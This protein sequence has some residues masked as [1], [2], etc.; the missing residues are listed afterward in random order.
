MT[1]FLSAGHNPKGIR[2]DSGAVN[3]DGIR[4]CDK[5]IEFRNLMYEAL[6]SLSQQ[7]IIPK[8][9]IM[10]QD[11]ERLGDYL[12]RIKTGD[13]SVVIE[14]HFDAF[15]GIAS[16]CTVLIGNDADRLDKAFA[17]EIVNK[18]SHIL[19]I[20][21]R[22]VKTETDSHRGKLGLMR[23]QGTV[24]LLE[25]GFIDNPKDMIQYEYWKRCLASELALIINRFEE[26]V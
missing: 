3:K 22:G 23:E 4:E 13:G 15:N 19:K 21:N 20:P 12:R 9:I 2:P 24:C 25:L 5:A 16:G 18:T 8:K 26:M 10:D 14:F 1:I 17:K 7:N 11:D 6:V